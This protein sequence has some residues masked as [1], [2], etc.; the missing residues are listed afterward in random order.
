MLVNAECHFVGHEKPLT[1]GREFFE[2]L[3][4][5]VS[6]YAQEFLSGVPQPASLKDKPDVVQLHKGNAS[7]LHRLTV[8][9]AEVAGT[10]STPPPLSGGTTGGLMVEQKSA[11]H[12]AAQVFDLTTVQLFDLVETVDQFLA[13]SRTLP[14]ISVELR[15]VSRRYAAARQPIVKRA[16]PAAL[17]VAGLTLAAL[18]FAF[19]PIPKVERPKEPTPQPKSKATTSPSPAP[20]PRSATKSQTLLASL[21]EITDPTQLHFLQRK[22]YN[23]IDRAWQSRSGLGNDLVYRVGVSKEGAIVGYKPVTSAGSDRAKATPLPE[24]LSIPATGTT[25]NTEPLAQFKVVFTDRG[26]LQVS[27]WSGYKGKPSLGAEITDASQL[28]TLN[29]QLYAEIKQNWK[30]TPTY[31]ENLV[32]RVAMTKDGVI[33]DYEPTNQ[34]AFD[35]VGETPLPDLIKDSGSASSVLQEPLGQFQVVF[36]PSGVLEVSRW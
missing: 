32:Y 19:V 14:D 25:P 22:V 34:S 20:T 31:K 23:K 11:M 30:G 18:G 26:I 1:G 4:M 10:T 28:R 6:S 12:Q 29:K 16:T 7:N 13:D 33:A 5:S 21:P 36:K 15:P 8:K 9:Q 35:Y 3:V 17:G 27:P 24:L 2:S